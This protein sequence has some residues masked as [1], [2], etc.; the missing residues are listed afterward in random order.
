MARIEKVIEQE[1][2][3]SDWIP[4]TMALYRMACCDCGLVHDMKFLAVRVTQK[5]PD[6][7]WSYRE[8]DPEKYRVVFKAT[9]NNRSTGQV[10]RHRGDEMDLMKLAKK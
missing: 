5:L 4:P 8:L 9:R 2:G 3:W 7:S 1:D 10:R 6:G